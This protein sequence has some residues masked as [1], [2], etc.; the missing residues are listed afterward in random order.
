MCET[1]SEIPIEF[2]GSVWP[3]MSSA[4]RGSVRRDEGRICV[5]PQFVSKDIPAPIGGSRY[6]EGGITEGRT[7]TDDAANTDCVTSHDMLPAT[8]ERIRFCWASHETV[9]QQA[10]P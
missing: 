2:T 5:K 4:A 8:L 1:A 9:V 3:Y 6:V 7:A 10:V